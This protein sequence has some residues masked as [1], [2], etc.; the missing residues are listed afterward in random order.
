MTIEACADLVRRGDP[1]RFFSGMTAPP[2]Q[3]GPLMV[4]YAFNLEVARAPWVTAEPLIAEMRLQWWRDVVAEIY[5]GRA[6]R[7]HEVATPLAQVIDTHSLPRALFDGL[8][9]ARFWDIQR[10]PHPDQRSFEAY[11]QATAGNLMRLAGHTLVPDLSARQQQAVDDY[12]RATGTAAFLRALPALSKTGQPLLPES[13]LRDIVALARRALDDLTVAKQTLKSAPKPIRPAL[14]AG[15]MAA[16][17][18]KRATARP[19][20]VLQG[21][22]EVSPARKKLFLLVKSAVNGF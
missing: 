12:A 16:T 8:I 6:V 18:L 9:E 19:E 15:W 10:D 20:V 1:D 4:L 17:T 2:D 3:R 22:L 5:E 13:G 7:R 21:G 11:I 14:R